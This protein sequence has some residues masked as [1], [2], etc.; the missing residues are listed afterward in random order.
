MACL[1]SLA[2]M[3]P[4]GVV[5][6]IFR[7]SDGLF[8]PQLTF[9]TYVRGVNGCIG[10][11]SN[12]TIPEGYACG[13]IGSS[14][15]GGNDPAFQANSLDWYWTQ[16]VRT[17]P[18]TGAAVADGDGRMETYD[19]R[20]GRI[21]DLGG[22]ANR[23]VLFPITDHGPFPCEAFEYSVWLTNDPETTLIATEAAPNPLAWN[24]ARLIR[25][26]TEGWTTNIN[27]LG[28]S[29]ASRPDLDA[30]LHEV[31]PGVPPTGGTA[32]ADALAT[33]WALPCGLTFRYVAI[34]GGNYGNPG[35]ECAY[36][37]NEDELDAVA[38]L[39][40]DD[41]AICIDADGDGHRAASCGGGDCDDTNPEIHPGAFEPCNSTIDYDCQPALECPSGTECDATSG[42]CTVICFE[43]SC[44]DGYTCTAAGLCTEAAC[45]ARTEP[46]PSGT[47]CRA[48]ACVGPCDGVT[49]PV[50]RICAGGACIDPCAG[51][52]CPSM[53]VCIAG[54]PGALTV[55]GPACTCLD[56]PSTSL[57]APG[58]TCDAR[59]G[60]PTTG[61]CVDPGCETATCGPGESCMDGTCV[62]ACAGVVC[63]LGQE[64]RLGECVLDRC[65]SVTCPLG[66]VC[67][68]GDCHSACEGVSCPTGQVCADGACVVDPCF[69]VDC[70]PTARCVAG[71]CVNLPPDAGPPP[72]G[73]GTMDGGSHR[74]PVTTGGC[75]RAA[76]H[77]SDAGGVFLAL[78][79][80]GA[81]LLRRRR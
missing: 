47:V 43:D 80:L 6:D 79:A 40:E 10:Y 14:P 30:W 13:S 52:V 15:P 1:N 45:A 77:G 71:T 3:R 63:P 59:P 53:Q 36:H 17:D 34:Q 56:L 42:L 27:A 41:T 61:L 75:C 11:T 74:P 46:C 4:D 54:T 39:N 67:R 22:E 64:C 31:V 44:A 19:P 9:A 50:G 18:T 33:V 65:A 21:Y 26:F 12:R 66:E 62:D 37:S 81:V 38:G 25:T 7:T 57:C 24:P 5:Y 28:A 2:A 49:C 16:V 69:G 73:G 48:G 78:L 70:G 60:S 76:G 23:V 68:D 8:A 55:C 29:E 58:T 35:P 72:D 20:R 32:V 51:V